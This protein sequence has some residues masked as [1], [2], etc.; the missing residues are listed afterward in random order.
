MGGWV[1]AP[2]APGIMGSGGLKYVKFRVLSDTI[3]DNLWL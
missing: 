3:A 1:P 2:E